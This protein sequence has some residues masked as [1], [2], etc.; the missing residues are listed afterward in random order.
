MAKQFTYYYG[1]LEA[2]LRAKISVG[3]GKGQCAAGEGKCD[4]HPTKE[5]WKAKQV[6][7]GAKTIHFDVVEKADENS[8]T[9]E[10]YN[11]ENFNK[12]YNGWK[13]QLRV[14]NIDNGDV[15]EIR[16]YEN[17]RSRKEAEE[18]VLTFPKPNGTTVDGW[19]HNAAGSF[20]TY[21]PMHYEKQYLYRD[22]GASYLERYMDKSI[23]KPKPKLIYMSNPEELE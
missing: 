23:E 2:P 19:L 7:A 9:L 15:E 4:E 5:Q 22:S 18:I 20:F 8:V 11:N 14:I 1:P 21:D 17:L 12:Y 3:T 16:V 13:L 10:E 6:A